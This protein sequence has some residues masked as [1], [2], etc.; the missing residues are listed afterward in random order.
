MDLIYVLN[1]YRIIIQHT[2]LIYRMNWTLHIM[3]STVRASLSDLNVGESR[4][5]KCFE[6]CN[7]IASI[8]DFLLLINYSCESDKQMKIKNIK[9]LYSFI[10]SL[11]DLTYI[12]KIMNISTQQSI[13]R[14][15]SLKSSL[16]KAKLYQLSIVIQSHCIII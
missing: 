1:H 6:T 12:H 7:L 5:E 14:Y 11:D 9:K 15:I 3:E 10:S 2:N 4:K 16:R 13:L 8:S